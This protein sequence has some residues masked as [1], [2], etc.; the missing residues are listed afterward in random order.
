MGLA[1]MPQD[2]AQASLQLLLNISRE[3]AT[4]LDLHTVLVRVLELST[5]HLNAERAS[6]IA[7]TPEGKPVDAAMIT[8][9]RLHSH[10]VDQLAVTVSRGL[11]GWVLRHR[12]PAFVPDTSLDERWVRREDDSLDRTGPKSA[13]CIPLLAQD[14]LAG[15]LTIVHSQPNYFTADHLNLLQAIAVLSGIAVRN[16]Q[17]YES[18]EA[19]RK[20]Y[21]DLFEDSIDPIALTDWE[22][23]VVEGNRRLAEFIGL[24]AEELKQHAI[25]ELHAVHWDKLGPQFEHLRG[26]Q[27]VSYESTS[28][29]A[30]HPLRPVQVTVRHI[31][32]GDTGLLQWI[33]RD[34]SERK[35]LDALR[36]DLAAMIY[37]DLRSPLAN[38]VSS[39]DILG[40]LLPPEDR[41]SV[42]PLYHIAVRSTDRMQRMINS[43]LDLN[44]LEAGQP[45]AERHPVSPRTLVTEAVDA[46]SPILEGKGQ[47]LSVVVP[48]EM[49]PVLADPDMIR[50]VIINLLENAGKF[51]P[52]NGSIAVGGWVEDGWALLWV[53]DSGPG[54]PESARELIFE[55]FNR[56]KGENLPKGFG[57]G[58][59]FC[60]LAV[61]AHGGRIWVEDRQ[62]NGSR[63]IFRL[64]AASLAAE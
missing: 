1:G 10:T 29:Y 12:E 40:S 3:L 52:M 38:I 18:M 43:L 15:V 55:K 14:Q 45:L 34:I 16:A 50:R 62:P 36:E 13:I 57:L 35:E 19:A 63:F 30:D 7:L 48:A 6:L 59:A 42:R 49:P 5:R 54:I 33:L 32:T 60:R 47:Q 23:R 44:R 31:E 24:P 64:P 58:L 8:E 61:Q 25:T 37:H 39:L 28:R 22:G 17:L 2:R 11:A 9:G 46:V 26:G 20:R 27:T 4:T 53:E 21:H 56:L 51:S 41:E